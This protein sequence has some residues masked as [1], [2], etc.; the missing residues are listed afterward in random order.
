MLGEAENRIENT[1]MFVYVRSR[2][3]LGQGTDTKTTEHT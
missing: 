1:C 2:S 3:K